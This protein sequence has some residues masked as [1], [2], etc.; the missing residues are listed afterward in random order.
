MI[1]FRPYARLVRL[2]NLPTAL[3]DVSMAALAVGLSGG[4]WPAFL[5]LLERPG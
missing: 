1:R 4:R 3:A 5:L 2:P